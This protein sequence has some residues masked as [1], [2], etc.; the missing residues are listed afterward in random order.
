MEKVHFRA[1]Y[2]PEE[3][4]FKLKFQF[5]T[6]GPNSP[7]Y[8]DIESDQFLKMVEGAEKGLLVFDGQN[9]V[10]KDKYCFA[11]VD[12]LGNDCEIRLS[13]TDK[14]IFTQLTVYLRKV[15]DSWVLWKNQPS[16][17]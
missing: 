15:Y 9:K 8:W 2:S 7:A 3:G 13:D 11:F 10:G 6:E 4:L 17:N 12:K 16:K 1:T 14:E 5:V